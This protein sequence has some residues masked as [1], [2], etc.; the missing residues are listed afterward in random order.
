[1]FILDEIIFTVQLKTRS[2][3]NVNERC[4]NDV[5]LYDNDT[6]TDTDTDTDI[7]LHCLQLFNK[8]N[9]TKYTTQSTFEIDSNY[10]YNESNS[11]Q[12]T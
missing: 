8:F 12:Y 4:C 1:M 3:R 11:A 2:T 10:V 5:S 7:N 6:E 9:Q